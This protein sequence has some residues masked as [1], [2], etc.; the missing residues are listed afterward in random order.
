MGICQSKPKI[1]EPKQSIKKM[2][3]E[4]RLMPK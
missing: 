4:Y 1:D 2:P 3:T